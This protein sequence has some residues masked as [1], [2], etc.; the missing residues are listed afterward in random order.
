MRPKHN[1]WHPLTVKS[2][3]SILKIKFAG[4]VPILTIPHNPPETISATSVSTLIHP[5]IILR[6]RELDYCEDITAPPT[7]CQNSLDSSPP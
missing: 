5:P 4:N 2:V 1:G 7:R 6:I 3:S